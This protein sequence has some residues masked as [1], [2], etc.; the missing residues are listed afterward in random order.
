MRSPVIPHRVKARMCICDNRRLRL[1]LASPDRVVINS[2]AF[3][4]AIHR[5]VSPANTEQVRAMKF[6]DWETH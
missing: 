1:S 2:V 6:F 4:Y 5:S 3:T